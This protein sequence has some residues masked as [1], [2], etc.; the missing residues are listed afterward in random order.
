MLQKILEELTKELLE[1]GSSDL[2]AN[3]VTGDEVG[4]I[5][6]LAENINQFIKV[7]FDFVEAS[8][9]FMTK[10]MELQQALKTQYSSGNEAN[11]KMP[12][13]LKCS[14]LNS[15]MVIGHASCV[16]FMATHVHDFLK[17]TYMQIFVQEY[18]SRKA[19]AAQA[20]EADSKQVQ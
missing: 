6:P 7:L 2:K 14:L 1:K 12:D 8:R 11:E 3:A 15:Q 17:D 9:A 10:E 4:T 18:F 19:Q 16:G 13:Y 20:A 5:H